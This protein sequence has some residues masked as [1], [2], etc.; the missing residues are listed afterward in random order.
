M[1][2]Y[3]GNYP[4]F[5]PDGQLI[6]TAQSDSFGVFDAATYEFLHYLPN[7]SGNLKF[8]ISPDSTL[9]LYPGT[10]N[11]ALLCDISN[12]S[13]F[14]SFRLPQ[15]FGVSYLAFSPNVKE[16]L[17]ANSNT[18]YFWDIDN[19]NKTDT[20]T[21]P[22]EWDQITSVDYYKDSNQI[23]IGAKIGKIFILDRKTFSIQYELSGPFKSISTLV[24]SNQGAVVNI[25]SQTPSAS[26]YSW[27]LTA[28]VEDFMLQ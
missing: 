12:G 26:L 15:G 6:Y 5:S 10:G 17:T 1:N 3:S 8:A 27:K 14:Q 21:I 28:G 20:F 9:I 7:S 13:E 18:V 4:T 2:V 19:G 24:V 23:I 25:F 16:C 11:K 22:P